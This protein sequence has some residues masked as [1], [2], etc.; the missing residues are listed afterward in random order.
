MVIID[1]KL[2][3]LF[4]CKIIH[5]NVT[6]HTHEATTF[7]NFLYFLARSWDKTQRRGGAKSYLGYTLCRELEVMEE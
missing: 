6:T 2:A 4:G 1:C 5:K 3:K 7:A